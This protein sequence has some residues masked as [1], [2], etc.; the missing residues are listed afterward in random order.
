MVDIASIALAATV[1][2]FYLLNGDAQA[3]EEATT[4]RPRWR[5]NR[6]RT[7]ASRLQTVERPR[8]ASFFLR[9]RV[10][11]KQIS[12]GMAFFHQFSCVP[13]Y[14]CTMLLLNFVCV[15]CQVSVCAYLAVASEDWWGSLDPLQKIQS[16]WWRLLLGG[17]AS[18]YTAV[19]LFQCFLST[20]WCYPLSFLNQSNYLL[21]LGKRHPM[22]IFHKL[23]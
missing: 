5:N 21:E 14:T 8:M 7:G 22:F 9:N 19:I 18:P 2:V 10:L 23:F 15:C 1:G 3:R 12:F 16:Y 4:R 6:R 20:K 13:C 11:R 17:G